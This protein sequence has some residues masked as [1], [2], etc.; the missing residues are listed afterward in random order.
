MQETY[1]YHYRENFLREEYEPC[2]VDAT[3]LARGCAPWTRRETA[4]MRRVSMK[5][6]RPIRYPKVLRIRL[7][8]EAIAQLEKEAGK[9]PISSYA[10][11]KIEAVIGLQ[12]SPQA[13]STVRAPEDLAKAVMRLG[14]L[15]GNIQRIYTVLA[16]NGRP[17]DDLMII[18][19]EL[20]EASAAVR[21][22]IGSDN[23]P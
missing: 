11:R 15:A 19:G 6:S 18:K 2:R 23:D 17:D 7:T 14:S 4:Q 20:R 21:R 8:F 1:K 22:A 9:E 3:V 10:R 16:A 5:P 12:Q 13:K